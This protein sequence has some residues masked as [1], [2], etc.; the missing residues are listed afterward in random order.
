[1]LLKHARW[2]V[3]MKRMIL[4]T[5]TQYHARLRAVGMGAY[6][7]LETVLQVEEEAKEKMSRHGLCTLPCRLSPKPCE[8]L[9][10]LRLLVRTRR[11]R[12]IA[13]K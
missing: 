5:A 13:L 2:R 8:Q 12:W 7:Q 9:L 6:S 1:M 3:A 11:A 10:R 4:P